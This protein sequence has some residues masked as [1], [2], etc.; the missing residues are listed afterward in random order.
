MVVG[1]FDGLDFVASGVVSGAVCEADAGGV[2]SI[3]VTVLR[4]GAVGFSR[5]KNC[6]TSGM[7]NADAQAMTATNTVRAVSLSAL[8]QGGFFFI[9]PF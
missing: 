8:L 9:V 7:K 3:C 2:V 6:R 4:A 5:P 1:F